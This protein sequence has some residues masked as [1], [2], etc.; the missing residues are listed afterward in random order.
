MDEFPWKNKLNITGRLHS[1]GGSQTD[2]LLFFF[3]FL[4]PFTFPWSAS[5]RVAGEKNNAFFDERRRGV[6]KLNAK[7]ISYHI[8]HI[9]QP[10]C[11]I[12]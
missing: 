2:P 11:A 10:Q 6:R 3:S 12:M 8:T 1:I 4:F 5:A 7:L 9:Q